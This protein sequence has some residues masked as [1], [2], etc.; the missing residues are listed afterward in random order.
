M[1]WYIDTNIEVGKPARKNY[2]DATYYG[3]RAHGTQEP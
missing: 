1:Y 2:S 3:H